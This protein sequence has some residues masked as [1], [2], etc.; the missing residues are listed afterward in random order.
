[1][2]GRKIFHWIHDWR[3]MIPKVN[4]FFLEQEAKIKTDAI[5]LRAEEEASR[6]GQQIT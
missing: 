2:N 4:P 1:M 3:A 5:L 6:R